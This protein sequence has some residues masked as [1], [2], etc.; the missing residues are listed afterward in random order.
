MIHKGIF[1][2]GVLAGATA[3]VLLAPESGKETRDKLKK[4]G[5]KIKDQFVS[6]FKEVKDDLNKAAASGKEKFKKETKDFASKAS[7]KTESII[8]IIE[9]QL[10]VLKEKNRTFQQT[11]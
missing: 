10:A 9:K 5:S 2:L 11:S 8:T 6:D 3:G 4:E 7:H 1:V